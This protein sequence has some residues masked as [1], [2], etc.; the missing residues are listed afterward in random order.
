MGDSAEFLF[1]I[2]N[3]FNV[4]TL[5]KEAISYGRDSTSGELVEFKRHKE[6][7]AP[8]ILVSAKETGTEYFNQR[9]VSKDPFGVVSDMSEGNSDLFRGL[10]TL[11]QLEKI[12]MLLIY[13][14]KK[15]R[16]PKG[17]KDRMKQRI[18]SINRENITYEDNFD[19]ERMYADLKRVLNVKETREIE[20]I[21]EDNE[22]LT[23]LSIQLAELKQ[24][25]KKEYIEKVDEVNYSGGSDYLVLSIDRST[26]GSRELRRD[27]TA[28][29]IQE[30]ITTP[31]GT[32]LELEFVVVYTD[33]PKHYMCY[34]KSVEDDMWYLYN[35]LNK[36]LRMVGDGSFE[37]MKAD[38]G[39]K[40]TLLFYSK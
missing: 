27:T 9:E 4:R 19:V 26:K 23:M 15:T 1:T 32:R 16:I 11:V 6:S 39:S 37:A 13:L 10:E 38:S 28:F 24:T 3:G 36:K 14:Q 35:D 34:F 21:Y 7:T 22:E 20:R 17:Q 12:K 8:I 25:Y 33:S 29:N 40:C 30:S 2:F 31:I 18:D 5:T